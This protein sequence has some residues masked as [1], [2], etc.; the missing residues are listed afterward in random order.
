MCGEAFDHNV[1]LPDGTVLLCPQ[2]YGMKHVLGNLF[3]ESYQDIINSSE[4][5][6]VKKG[7]NGDCSIE[8]LCRSCSSASPF[9]ENT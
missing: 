3:Y 5:E 6:K 9:V 7:C 8:I 1:I 2:D 4:M